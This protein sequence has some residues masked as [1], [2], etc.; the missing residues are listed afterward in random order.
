M[1][2]SS[3]DCLLAETL[4]NF[5][6]SES[7][8]RS[9]LLHFDRVEI[10]SIFCVSRETFKHHS[11]CPEQKTC[12]SLGVPKLREQAVSWLIGDS[13]S[14]LYFIFFPQTAIHLLGLLILSHLWRWMNYKYTLPFTRP[15]MLRVVVGRKMQRAIFF[16]SIFDLH[17]TTSRYKLTQ[18][19]WIS[20]E[21]RKVFKPPHTKNIFLFVFWAVLTGGWAVLWAI[22][23]SFFQFSHG[24]FLLEVTIEEKNTRKSKS[25]VRKFTLCIESLFIVLGCEIF[26]ARLQ[27]QEKISFSYI[28][29]DRTWGRLV[30]VSLRWR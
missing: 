17:S 19:S 16:S 25:F 30:R 29:V 18:W 27:W 1:L 6:F 21:S 15:L 26:F 2:F 10:K 4:C 11:M 9:L 5:F 8:D 24:R 23:G 22:F 13:S 7:L 12:W 14:L 20:C 3:T 28:I